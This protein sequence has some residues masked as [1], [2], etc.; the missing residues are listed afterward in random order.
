MQKRTGGSSSP[1]APSPGSRK[2]IFVSR[3]ATFRSPVSDQVLVR[4]R[5]L[6]LDPYMR[7]RMSDAP[8]Y[9]KPVTIG[10]V[11]IGGTAGEVVAVQASGL[12]PR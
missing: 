11:M 1:A 4:N 7:G 10:E 6:S 9:A 5:W 12:H 8:S 2:A 3:K